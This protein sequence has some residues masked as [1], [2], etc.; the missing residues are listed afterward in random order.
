MPRAEVSIA[1]VVTS[2]FAEKSRSRNR[3]S[4]STTSFLVPS[5]DSWVRQ[6]TR[7][8]R[9]PSLR[10]ILL[11][12]LSLVDVVKSRVQNSV[13]VIFRR[14][15]VAALADS[16]LFIGCWRHSEVQL[17]IPLSRLDRSRRR[18][19]ST[20]FWI[21]P[22]GPSTRSRRRSSV[23]SGR[24]YSRCVPEAVGSAVHLVN[25]E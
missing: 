14:P 4:C 9:S 18:N 23:A 11:L 12:I 24:I 17:D 15:A 10:S 13:K 21:P 5:E 20:L 16:Q 8:V 3:E 22:Q 2:D 1:H 25:R 7:P 19:R 6:S